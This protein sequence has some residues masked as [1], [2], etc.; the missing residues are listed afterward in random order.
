[1]GDRGKKRRYYSVLRLIDDLRLDD[2]VLAL[3]DMIIVLDDIKKW[4]AFELAKRNNSFVRGA[5]KNL[6]EASP[7]PI[8]NALAGTYPPEYL[9]WQER[10]SIAKEC[11]QIVIEQGGWRPESADSVTKDY[12]NLR[13]RALELRLKVSQIEESIDVLES[14][15]ELP[16]QTAATAGGQEAKPHNLPGGFVG[17]CYRKICELPAET[18]AGFLATNKGDSTFYD[19]RDLWVKEY[20]KKIKDPGQGI[21]RAKKHYRE[22]MADELK[23]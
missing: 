11:V 16:P 20:K 15:E 22:V 14:I 13:L 19:Y 17:F 1:M 8:V 2:A 9:A 6:K 10:I 4:E 7:P 12:L 21:S 3:Q 23:N 18:R 5:I